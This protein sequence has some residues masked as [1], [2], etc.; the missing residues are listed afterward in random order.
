M[1]VKEIA[2]AFAALCREGR[3]AEA[4]ERFWSDDI[5][6]I[7][8]ST[9]EMAHLEGREAVKAK[10]AWW[11]ANHEVHGFETRG[12]YLNGAQFALHFTIDVTPKTT[13][14]RTTQDEL[15][16]YTVKDGKVVEE[17]FFH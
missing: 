1:T 6:S 4:G 13:G 10:T 9:G 8:A 3:F 15:A 14:E 11:E 5:V 7:E 16:V 12:P 2:E 17:R